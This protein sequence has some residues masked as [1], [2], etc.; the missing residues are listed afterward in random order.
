MKATDGVGD[1]KCSNALGD[2]VGALA[3]LSRSIVAPDDA[4]LSNLGGIARLEAPA[5]ILAEPP[6][7][8]VGGWLVWT[9]KRSRLVVVV[10][11]LSKLDGIASDFTWALVV[12]SRTRLAV[13]V[14]GLAELDGIVRMEAPAKFLA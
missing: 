7:C 14:T 3:A 13:V 6:A 8:R 12:L 5:K 4:G 2:G 10:T 11:G 1:G 9:P